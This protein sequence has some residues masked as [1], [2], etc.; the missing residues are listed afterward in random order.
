[1]L[2]NK[3]KFR[4]HF[5]P[6]MSGELLPETAEILQFIIYYQIYQI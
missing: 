3:S 2:I 1:M 4:E 5:G 6:L